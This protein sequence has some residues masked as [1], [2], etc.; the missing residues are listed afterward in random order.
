LKDYLLV[1]EETPAFALS[2]ELC[3]KT[4]AKPFFSLSLPSMFD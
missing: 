2:G 1:N 4:W 3:G